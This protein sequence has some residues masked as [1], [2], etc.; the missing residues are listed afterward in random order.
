MGTLSQA[1]SLGG[2]G[3]IL[4][5]FIVSLL[6]FPALGLV[7]AI[8][9]FVM[10]LIAVK[11]ISDSLQDNSIFKDMLIAVIVAIVGF[12]AVGETFAAGIS[13]FAKLT[14]LTPSAIISTPGFR[15]FAAEFFV[16]L[17]FGWIIL[18]VSAY[19]LRKAYNNVGL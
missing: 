12:V 3:S 16:G 19:F 1:K 2:I 14:N 11:Y 7:L 10:T 18:V 15:T 13:R 17:L 8:I 4:V 6:A 5:L 9:G